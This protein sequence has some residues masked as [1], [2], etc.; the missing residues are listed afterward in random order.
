MSRLMRRRSVERQL[1]ASR[2][3]A[4]PSASSRRARTHEW[5]VPSGRNGETGPARPPTAAAREP[6]GV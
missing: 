5:A 4:R 1:R 2:R 3:R 6:Q